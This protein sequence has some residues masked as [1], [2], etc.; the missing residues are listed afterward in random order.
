MIKSPPK[1]I[2]NKV[3]QEKGFFSP[4]RPS[5]FNFENFQLFNRYNHGSRS[6]MI[7]ASAVSRKIDNIKVETRD[8]S[9]NSYE[10]SLS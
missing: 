4:Y 2:S 8:V 6:N 7:M 10:T 3:P 1:M 5:K 9:K